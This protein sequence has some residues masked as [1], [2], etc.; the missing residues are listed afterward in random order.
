MA[1]LAPQ[2]AFSKINDEKQPGE[3]RAMMRD[4]VYKMFKRKPDLDHIM[5]FFAR[6]QGE[7]AFDPELIQEKEDHNLFQILFY[8]KFYK[9]HLHLSHQVISG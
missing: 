2:F 9:F 5:G 8:W 6:P 3:W 4:P 7:A 1:I